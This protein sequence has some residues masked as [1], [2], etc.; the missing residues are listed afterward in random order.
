MPQQNKRSETATTGTAESFRRAKPRVPAQKKLQQ[1]PPVGLA[2]S[3]FP[4]PQTKINTATS[5]FLRTS[6][7]SSLRKPGREKV[8]KKLKIPEKPVPLRETLCERA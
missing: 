5:T 8:Q 7:S 4:P 3:F 2:L 1:R 6:T